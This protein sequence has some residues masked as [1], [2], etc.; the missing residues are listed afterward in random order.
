MILPLHFFVLGK[1]QFTR[2]YV[3][4]VSDGQ[5]AVRQIFL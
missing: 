5:C 2:N 4:Q 3:R 1:V